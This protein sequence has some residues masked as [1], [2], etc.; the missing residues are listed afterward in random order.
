M[1]YAY[2]SSEILMMASCTGIQCVTKFR[3]VL[4]GSDCKSITVPYKSEIDIIS[5]ESV[6]RSNAGRL[7][8]QNRMESGELPPYGQQIADGFGLLELLD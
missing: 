5:D 6:V 1:Y 2:D 7:A 3:K 4:A 8:W